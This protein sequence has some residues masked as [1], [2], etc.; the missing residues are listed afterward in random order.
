VTDLSLFV[1]AGISFVPLAST[2]F[3]FACLKTLNMRQRIYG[4]AH[5]LITVLAFSYGITLDTH[6]ASFE[7][8]LAGIGSLLLYFLAIASIVYCFRRFSGN[9][10]FHLLHLGTLG[11]VSVTAPFVVL[12]IGCASGNCS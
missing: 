10:L 11:F 2:T 4:S 9:R 7:F 5:G 1:I 12:F 6:L 8:P 3:F